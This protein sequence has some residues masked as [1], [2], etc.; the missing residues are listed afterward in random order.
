MYQKSR[1]KQT[2]KTSKTYV[3]GEYQGASQKAWYHV[4]LTIGRSEER[5]AKSPTSLCN[6]MRP[7][8][9]IKSNKNFQRAGKYSSVM[10]HVPGLYNPRSND[11]KQM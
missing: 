5:L 9:E 2:I 1:N 8:P 3:L 11:Q 6:L 7:C 4:I 10:E